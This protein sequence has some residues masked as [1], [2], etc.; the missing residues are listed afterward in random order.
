MKNKRMSVA[1]VDKEKAELLTLGVDE[2]VKPEQVKGRTL[3]T[4]ISAG[5][6][7]AVYRGLYPRKSKEPVRPGYAAVFEVEEV[8]SEVTG[9]HVGEHRFCM[10]GHRTH[11]VADASE[12]LSVPAGLE[13]EKAVFARMMGVTTTT[14]TTTTA[15]PGDIVMVTGL[16]P[17]GF[18]AALMFKRC[19]YRVVGVDPD[20][21][22]RTLAGERGIETVFESVPVKD[23]TISGKV[24]LVV[25]CSGHE[26][27][28]V[29]ACRV[30]EKRGEVVLVGVPWE[31]RTE[32]TAHELL[33]A[34]FHKYVVLRSGWEWEL[35]AYPGH[36]ESHC[37]WN[38]FAM[39]LDWLADGSVN[40]DGLGQL[41]DPQDVQQAYQDIL[42]RRSKTLVTL[43]DW[44]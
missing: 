18:M 34:V 14:L 29:D 22:R 32:L 36:F 23:S 37:R 26:Q 10:G 11:M 41:V 1:L 4:L 25:E 9:I 21:T 15:R 43:L 30:V 28:T 6:E 19:G 42:H 2:A 40:V 16:G 35:P 27:A 5:T 7:L 31:Q 33:H 8:G 44:Q 24:A 39:A 13:P 12:T 3:V 17:V 38:N 20:S